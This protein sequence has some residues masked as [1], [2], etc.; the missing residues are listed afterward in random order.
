MKEFVQPMLVRSSDCD[1][2]GRLTPLSVLVAMQEAAGE[3]SHYLGMGR[4]ALLKENAIWILTRSEMRLLKQP[5]YLDKLTVRTFPGAPRRLLFPRYFRFINEEGETAITASSYWA[6]MDVST[7][8][9]VLPEGI[10]GKMPD[11]SDLTP[12]MPPPG[13]ARLSSGEEQLIPYTPR[14]S[15][16]DLNGHVNNTRCAGWAADLMGEGTLRRTPIASLTVNYNREIRGQ[17][18]ILFSFRKTEDTFSL[19]CLRGGVSH[20]DVSGT[21]AAEGALPPSPLAAP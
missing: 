17:D 4:E 19:R 6:L 3:H 5:V 18:E 7:L 21:L 8:S 1:R 16:L 2:F 9:M 12:P 13:A 20:V 11:N 10:A 14:F 15:D